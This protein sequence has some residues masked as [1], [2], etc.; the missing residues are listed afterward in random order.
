MNYLR[1]IL[2]LYLLFLIVFYLILVY[3]INYIWKK[4]IKGDSSPIIIR[5]V[6]SVATVITFLSVLGILLLDW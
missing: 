5:V 4:S 6:V 2:G 1:L 3:Y